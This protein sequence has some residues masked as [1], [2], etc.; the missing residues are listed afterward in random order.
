[1]AQRLILRVA[2]AVLANGYLLIQIETADVVKGRNS[3]DVSVQHMVVVLVDYSG[4]ASLRPRVPPA[5]G[6]GPSWGQRA[7]RGRG[8]MVIRT[9]G[10]AD[11]PPYCD[12]RRFT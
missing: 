11:R 10:Y 6:W 8:G 1:M 5:T 2:L 9:E 12:G 4:L 3:D 7:N